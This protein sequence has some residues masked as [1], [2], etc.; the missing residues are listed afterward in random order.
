MSSDSRKYVSKLPTQLGE[1]VGVETTMMYF[2]I[3]ACHESVTTPALFIHTKSGLA[4][5][6]EADH[7]GV[8]D[9]PA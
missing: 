3:A 2:E 6:S 9:P 1:M 8:A 5:A 7:V 4:S